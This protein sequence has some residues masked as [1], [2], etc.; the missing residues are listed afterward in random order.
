M[1][2]VVI[3][4][5]LYDLLWERDADTSATLE[6]WQDV[7]ALAFTDELVSDHDLLVQAKELYEAYDYGQGT[8]SAAAAVLIALTEVVGE[9]TNR[10]P[11]DI[12][13][14]W[15]SRY[16]TKTSQPTLCLAGS[17]QPATWPSW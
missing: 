3:S 14:E 15:D 13:R 2:P 9:L 10:K 5:R 12:E 4:A 1:E 16:R 11:L 7:E 8:K 6:R 17:S